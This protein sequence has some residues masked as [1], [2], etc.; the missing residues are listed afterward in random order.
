MYD[1]GSS[2]GLKAGLLDNI[3][4]FTWPVYLFKLKLRVRLVGRYQPHRA[5][6]E[7]NVEYAPAH[8]QV[9]HPEHVYIINPS[10]EDAPAPFNSVRR[11]FVAGHFEPDYFYYKNK[12]DN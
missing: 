3:V 1:A 10:V 6:S 9:N 8:L 11:N 2:V 5:D 12:R 7:N 4:E